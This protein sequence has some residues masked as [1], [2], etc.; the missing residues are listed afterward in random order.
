MPHEIERVM[1]AKRLTGQKLIIPDLLPI[2]AHWPS[3][4]NEGYAPMKRSVGKKLSMFD[5]PLPSWAI[6][7]AN[8]VSQY[9]A[10]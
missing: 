10:E 2:F 8:L 9:T 5:A 1:L 7:H 3:R 4:Q 6:C